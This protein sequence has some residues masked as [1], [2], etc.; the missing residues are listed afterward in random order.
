MNLF[1]STKRNE[2]FHRAGINKSGKAGSTEMALKKGLI[3]DL[4]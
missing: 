4:K 2:G 3:L 1:K